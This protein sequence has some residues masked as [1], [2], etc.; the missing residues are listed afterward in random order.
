M[1]T[2]TAI[3]GPHAGTSFPLG[4]SQIIGR[5]ASNEIPIPED[6]G[7]SRRHARLTRSG[8]RYIVVDLQSSNGLRV[9][10]SVVKRLEVGDG[11]VL[12][13]GNTR[14]RIEMDQAASI[15]S[16]VPKPQPRAAP[17]GDAKIDVRQSA[18][19]RV[20]R[21][22]ADASRPKGLFALDVSQLSG[23]ALWAVMA[24]MLLFIA[25][26]AFLCYRMVA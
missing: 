18:S 14:F 20:L 16:A 10:G 23:P 25:A 11:D 3:D 5:L 2:L 7:A 15:P 19:T 4:A 12:L 22:K 13:V 6:T 21:S 1:D 9:N 17:S 26:L 24:A 8:D